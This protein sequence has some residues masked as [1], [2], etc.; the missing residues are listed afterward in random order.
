MKSCSW[1]GKKKTQTGNETVWEFPS[2]LLDFT[3][4]L[5]S[6]TKRK[7]EKNYYF[8]YYYV[9]LEWFFSPQNSWF[10]ALKVQHGHQTHQDHVYWRPL[11]HQWQE[12][13]QGFNSMYNNVQSGHHLTPRPHHMKLKDFVLTRLTP[14]CLCLF[15]AS[16][17]DSVLPTELLK[18]VF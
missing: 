4:Y 13:L 14:D 17:D 1:I 9:L 18:G 16:G 7:G 11:P 6:A 15:A 8:F 12:S 3:D 2:A 5:V 10:L